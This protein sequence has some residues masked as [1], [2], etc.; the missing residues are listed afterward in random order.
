MLEILNGLEE[1]IKD[2]M[3]SIA[4]R[5]AKTDKSLTRYMIAAKMSEMLDREISKTRLDSM[6]SAGKKKCHIHADELIAFCSLFGD[7]SPISIAVQPVGQF[8]VTQEERNLIEVALIDKEIQE[9]T[10]KRDELKGGKK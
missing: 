10:K 1:D 4:K 8:L 9:L 6:L 5:A 3:S 7:Y 2:Q